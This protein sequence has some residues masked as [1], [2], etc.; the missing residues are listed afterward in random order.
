MGWEPFMMNKT[1]L[2]VGFTRRTSFA[3]AKVL[4]EMGNRIAVSDSVSDDEKKALLSEIAQLGAVS[5]YLGRQSPDIL[6]RIEPDMVLPSPGVPLNIPLIEEA[7]RRGIEVIGD[8]ELFYR[9]HPENTYI[10]ITGTDGKT[11]TTTLIYEMIRRAKDAVIGGNVGTPV[12]EHHHRINPGTVIILELS[13]FQLEEIERFKPRIAVLLNIAED[14]M[15]RYPSMDEY[16][17]AKL[18]IFMNQTPADSAI[19]NK[20]CAYCAQI[21]ES[22]PVRPFTFSLIDKSAD[23]YYDKDAVYYLGKKYI[24]RKKIALIGVHNVEN[25]MAAILTAKQAGIPDK[26]IKRTLTEFCGLEHRLEF[27]REIKGVKIYNDSKST[28]VNSLEKALLS[29]NVPVVLIAGGKDK[30][31]DFTVL[32]DTL[33]EKVKQLILIGEAADKIDR[34]LEFDRT[35]R[36]DTLRSAVEQ[37]FSAAKKGDVIVLSP[38]CASFDMFRNYVERGERFKEIVNELK[39]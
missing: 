3:A 2:I 20:E 28:T 37:A 27:V 22:Y 1:V 24:K 19:V 10:G 11:T 16:V 12:F 32:R 36:A 38:G 31:L 25:A 6:D 33:R 30:G 29:F 4:L 18:R 21:T 26:V 23:I 7:K 8:V 17:K 39:S 14:H 34:Q 5:D 15:D 35:V 9:F 13:S